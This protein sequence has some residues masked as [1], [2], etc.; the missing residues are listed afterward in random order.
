MRVHRP[1]G[2]KN[3]PGPG[4]AQHLLPW[5]L[6]G[7]VENL[8]AETVW[9][10]FR[11]EVDGCDQSTI[12][13]SSEA[14]SRLARSDVDTIRGHLDGCRVTAVAYVRTP[15]SRMLSDYTQ[16]V[17]SGRC[18]LTFR[19]FL[20]DQRRLIEHYDSF[21]DHWD[22]V[23]GADSV[24]LRDYDA[25]VKGDGLEA[26]FASLL[27]DD[28]AALLD[29]RAARR[30]NVSPK[31]QVIRAQRG[32]N[33]LESRLG[34]PAATRRAFAAARKL[35]TFRFPSAVLRALGSDSPLHD[36]D[37]VAFVESQSGDRYR[38]LLRRC[39]SATLVTNPADGDLA[40]RTS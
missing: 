33:G 36:G 11:A 16:R 22:A 14:F 19:Q 17:K 20:E 21:V 1:G 29:F 39:R 40:C 30:L 5:S 27:C 4:N 15:L 24:V 37:D 32:I 34:R 6:L 10:A 25:A 28:P 31:K 26:D 2:L 7:E 3:I 35:A 8:R 9:T 12:I 13:A 38:S 18:D 23:F